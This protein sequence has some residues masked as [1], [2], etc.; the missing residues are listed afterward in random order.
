MGQESIISLGMFITGM[1]DLVDYDIE[2][3][4]FLLKKRTVV[5][6]SDATATILVSAVTVGR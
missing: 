1:V 4:T 2:M 5:S 3:R 6:V